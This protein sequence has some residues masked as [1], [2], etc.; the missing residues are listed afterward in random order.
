MRRLKKI[1]LKG[2]SSSIIICLVL[3]IGCSKNKSDDDCKF[4]DD[5]KHNDVRS[6]PN[7]KNI[8]GG[9]K[10]TLVD[11]NQKYKNFVFFDKCSIDPEK[12]KLEQTDL[13][14]D[15]MV[16]KITTIKQVVEEFHFDSDTAYSYFRPRSVDLGERYSKEDLDNLK[17]L[18]SEE[19]TQCKDG[20]YKLT[21]AYNFIDKGNGECEVEYFD[22]DGNFFVLSSG[23]EDFSL[24]KL[25]KP[26]CEDKLEFISDPDGGVMIESSDPECL[27]LK[28][29][30][31]E[32]VS[33]TPSDEIETCG[34]KYYLSSSDQDDIS[35]KPFTYKKGASK[36]YYL[37][38]TIFKMEK[39]FLWLSLSY[40]MREECKNNIDSIKFDEAFEYVKINFKTNQLMSQ[41]WREHIDYNLDGVGSS[42][43]CVVLSGVE[44]EHL[45]K[46]NE[47]SWNNISVED[48]VKK[49]TYSSEDNGS[50]NILKCN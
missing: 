5:C 4:D 12:N 9:W 1:I 35:R 34:Y 28:E 48:G 39:K 2:L 23:R 15:S 11:R 6:C 43:S 29:G 46:T 27:D 49:V 38:Y 18:A 20:E 13:G 50:I 19:K 33:Y 30:F 7:V 22:E 47:I 14:N 26:G 3:T 44:E 42:A 40:I 10:N 37:D 17:K 16:K 8:H 36:D 25:L 21:V 45:K 32:L 41:C 31:I 24:R